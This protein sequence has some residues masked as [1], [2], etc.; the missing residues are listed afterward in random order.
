MSDDKRRKDTI[1]EKSIQV[2]EQEVVEEFAMFPEWMDKYEYLIEIGK[3]LPMI[4]EACKTED[5]LIKGC[6]SRVWL[7]CR[8]E[9]G[10]LQFVADSDAIITKGIIALLIRVYNNQ[11]PEA[12]LASDF[13]FIQQIGLQENLTPTRASG[14]VS[15]I[16]RIKAYAAE[17][18]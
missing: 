18:C 8:M 9:D 1:M 11:T 13:G 14:L 15:M 7:D 5:K 17:N 6:Q 4:A 3:G 2:L 10:K 16:S 12:I